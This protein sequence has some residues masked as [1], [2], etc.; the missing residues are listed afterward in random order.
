MTLAR[1]LVVPLTA[2]QR[3]RRALYL[4]GEA[5]L[6]ELDVFVR[7]ENAPESCSVLYYRLEYPNGGVDPTAPD[8]GARWSKPG[9]AFVNRTADCMA[10]VAWVGGFDRYQPQRGIHIWGGRFNCD[11]MLIEATSSARCFEQLD[12]PEP[13]CIV[14][15]GSE[16]YDHDGDRDRVGH[17]GTVVSVP[18][19]WD[20]DNRE[21]WAQLGVVD[22]AGRT[23]RANC[24]TTGLTWFG[25]DRRGMPKNSR[26]LRSVMKP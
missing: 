17:T 14:V 23:G 26:F 8:P 24:R 25:R 20:P 19:V 12:A 16:D 5:T 22:I 10:G 3:V 2:D 9:S 21:C 13:G 15:Y 4:A 11:S 1:G 7:K 6:S 18:S